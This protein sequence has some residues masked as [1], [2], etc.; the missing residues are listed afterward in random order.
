MKIGDGNS[1]IGPLSLRVERTMIYDMNQSF[2]RKGDE[3]H[4]FTH[5]R[6]HDVLS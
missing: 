4:S 6:N 2:A 1:A 5:P 3:F